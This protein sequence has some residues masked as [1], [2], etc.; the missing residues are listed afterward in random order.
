MW[1]QV[2]EVASE[3][4][5]LTLSKESWEMKSVTLHV[6]VNWHL[7]R[8]L[9]TLEQGLNDNRTEFKDSCP[10]KPVSTWDNPPPSLD[11][12]LAGQRPRSSKGE[13]SRPAHVALIRGLMVDKKRDSL[14]S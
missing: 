12:Q 5:L 11:P 7:R 1:D 3:V 4:D 2:C 14:N 8:C 9:S 13:T 10:L 6:S